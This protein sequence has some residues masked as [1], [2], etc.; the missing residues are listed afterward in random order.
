MKVWIQV[1]LVA[2]RYNLYNVIH[3]RR[4]R[5]QEGG[6]FSWIFIHDTDKIEGGLG[7]IFRSC[8]FRWPPLEIFLPTS[9]MWSM[10]SLC[11]KQLQTCFKGYYKN[12]GQ[13][14]SP[15]PSGTLS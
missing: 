2:V 8:F 12:K 15:R 1:T 9:L 3:G 5:G 10:R 7:A 11:C 14:T 4:Q 13:F 6:V